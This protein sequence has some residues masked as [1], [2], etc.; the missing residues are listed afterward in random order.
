LIS[1][2]TGAWVVTTLDDADGTDGPGAELP[3]DVDVDDVD[4]ARSGEVTGD[5]PT[6]QA[7]TPTRT[8]AAH[9]VNS[10]RPVDG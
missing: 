8:T 9:S 2:G 4:G 6:P 1:T 3:T 7:P 5:C 10:A